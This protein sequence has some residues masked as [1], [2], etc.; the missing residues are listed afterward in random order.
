MAFAYVTTDS[1][2][3]S[4]CIGIDLISDLENVTTRNRVEQ[5]FQKFDS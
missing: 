2:S 1:L 3:H 5:I 4:I